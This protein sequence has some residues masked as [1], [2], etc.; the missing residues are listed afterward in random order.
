MTCRSSV[1]APAPTDGVRHGLAMVALRVLVAASV[2]LLLLAGT[3]RAQEWQ[4][5]RVEGG[6]TLSKRV[7]AGERFPEL[8]VQATTALPGVKLTSY[9]LGSYIDQADPGIS[10]KLVERTAESAEWTD[11]I[12]TP[13]ISDRCATTR[14]SL[15]RE[16]NSGGATVEFVSRGVWPTGKPST[17]CVPLRSHGSWSFQPVAGGTRVTY[18]IFADPGGTV[19]SFLVRGALEDDA[20]KRVARVLGAAGK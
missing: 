3:A 1:P 7:V 12:K 10:R 11:L 19:P 8:R 6:L 5:L 4:Q 18:T 2:P 20:L 17:G 14:L 15:R 16:E 9:L 13:I